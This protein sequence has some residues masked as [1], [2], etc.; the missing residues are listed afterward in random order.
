[1]WNK[2]CQHVRSFGIIYAILAGFL[3]ILFSEVCFGEELPEPNSVTALAFTSKNDLLIGRNEGLESY[4]V[5]D[6]QT[7]QV[8][9]DSRKVVALT[10]SYQGIVPR[11]I[12]ITKTNIE[13]APGVYEIFDTNAQP[14]L[15][16][17]KGFELAP[18]SAVA[19]SADGRLAVSI[20][21]KLQSRILVFDHDEK[22]R[23]QQCIASEFFGGPQP[24]QLFWEDGGSLVAV[25]GS[26]KSKRFGSNIKLVDSYSEA[27]LVVTSEQGLLSFSLSS[28]DSQL[29]F[30][31][32]D[33][34]K[35]NGLVPHHFVV[36]NGSASFLI[37]R[38]ARVYDEKGRLALWTSFEEKDE[39]T[40][41]A[42]SPDGELFAVGSKFG[43][44]QV[45]KTHPNL[46][47]HD[48]LRKE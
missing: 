9:G 16:S 36:K 33:L 34:E 41:S 1:M 11:V 21:E 7:R 37:G 26:C 43:K 45:M 4:D 14:L 44:V 29:K 42:F 47:G 24:N 12:G 27:N 15:W 28:K 8:L 6:G 35:S 25:F 13:A 38:Q 5:S 22:G 32:S 2:L 40:A 39:A 30:Q 31:K 48:R 3:S 20:L 17:I 10:T 46:D 18:L 19:I 23:V